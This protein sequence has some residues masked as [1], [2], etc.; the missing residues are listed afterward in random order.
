LL[1]KS[2]GKGIS[3][4]EWKGAAGFWLPDTDSAK[5]NKELKAD[6]IELMNYLI[7]EKCAH[8]YDNLVAGSV[9]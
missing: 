2:S 7:S 1:H 5:V 9:A 8:P 3:F 4:S 6:L